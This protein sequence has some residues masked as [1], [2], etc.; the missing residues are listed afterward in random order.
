[1][2]DNALTKLPVIGQLGVSAAL[3]ALI[4]GLFWYFY[5]SPAVDERD[6]KAAKLESMQKEIRALEVTAKKLQEFRR[7]VDLLERTL[8]TL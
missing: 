3:A 4:G 5:W 6:Q 7:E 1:M 2:A 8:E